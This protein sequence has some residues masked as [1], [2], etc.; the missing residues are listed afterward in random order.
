[1]VTDAPADES[2]NDST[3]AGASP[4]PSVTHTDTQRNRSCG[5]GS[6]AEAAAVIGEMGIVDADVAEKALPYCNIVCIT[7]DELAEKL[8]GYLEVLFEAEPTAVGGKLPGDDFYYN[9]AN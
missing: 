7:G 6:T 4:V 5:N 1:M 3:M 9:A 2:S 8:S